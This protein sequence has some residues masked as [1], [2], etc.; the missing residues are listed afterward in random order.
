MLQ[1]GESSTD[2]IDSSHV[3]KQEALEKEFL[4]LKS[5]TE[6]ERYL[7]YGRYDAKTHYHND[8]V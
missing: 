2:N 8:L 1:I 5:L 3:T 4:T 6:D 7:M